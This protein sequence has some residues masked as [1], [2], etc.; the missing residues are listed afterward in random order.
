[1][2]LLLQT[3]SSGRALRTRTA[4]SW[5]RRFA[6]CGRCACRVCGSHLPV[7]QL[8]RVK[9]PGRDAEQLEHLLLLQQRRGHVHDG[10]GQPQH[11]RPVQRFQKCAQLRAACVP[12]PCTF[13]RNMSVDNLQL[14]L[15]AEESVRACIRR[16]VLTCM[17][18]AGRLVG[19]CMQALTCCARTPAQIR[20]GTRC[21]RRPRTPTAASCTMATTS[22]KPSPSTPS[23]CAA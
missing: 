2:Y 8:W 18:H 11:D 19:A 13:T 12:V 14:S 1:M 7:H 16:R 9:A 22:T 20:T 23:L 6:C 4:H 21:W 10:R 5:E 15:H 17:Q 3:T